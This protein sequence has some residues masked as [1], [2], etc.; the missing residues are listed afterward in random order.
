M[1]ELAK[2]FDMA[3][4]SFMKHIGVLERSRLIV[5]R[6]A[7]RIRTCELQRESLMAAQRWFDEQR[8]RW[9][10]RYT[11]LDGLLAKLSGDDY[12]S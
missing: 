11:N 5:S 9:Q 8:E 1:S 3:L 4:P 12:E 10:D 6:K 2:P 7:G